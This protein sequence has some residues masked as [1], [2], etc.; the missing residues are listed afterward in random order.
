MAQAFPKELAGR[1]LSA[2]NLVIFAGVFVCQWGIGLAIDGL[3]AYGWDAAASH[4][5]AM[6]LL[7]LGMAV[8]G[9]WYW[10]Y[11][12]FAA[13]RANVAAAQG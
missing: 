1:A 13:R 8:A 3:V 7:L 11:P 12:R 9:V 6:G 5:A 10:A 4:R 2:F